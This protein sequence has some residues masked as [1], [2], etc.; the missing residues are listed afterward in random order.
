[1]YY[2]WVAFCNYRKC[3]KL[4]VSKIGIWRWT[5]IVEIPTL[6]SD[7]T[8]VVIIKAWVVPISFASFWGWV[9]PHLNSKIASKHILILLLS[10]DLFYSTHILPRF[11]CPVSSVLIKLGQSSPLG[12]KPLGQSSPLVPK[13]KL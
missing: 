13:P 10:H 2:I 6:T 11:K 7:M 5:H 1:M 9:R 12:L 4:Y 3:K 8:I